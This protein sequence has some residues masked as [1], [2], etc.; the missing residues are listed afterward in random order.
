MSTIT[1]VTNAYHKAAIWHAADT[2]KGKAKEPY[3]NHLVEVADLVAQATGGKDLNLIAAAV[4]HDSIEDGHAT[5]DQIAEEFGLDVAD[6]VAEVTDDTSLSWHD[7]KKAQVEKAATKTDRAK[8]LKLADKTSNL[9]GI[10]NSPPVDWSH[11]RKIK[12]L[13]QARQLVSEANVTNSII[14][15]AFEE[16]ARELETKLLS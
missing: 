15:N 4:L 11:E 3:I 13:R 10:L 7:R 2:R 1:F 9:R 5:Y 6:L 12:Y 8:L 16:V 14:S